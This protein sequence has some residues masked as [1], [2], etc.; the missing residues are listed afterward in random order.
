MLRTRFHLNKRFIAKFISAVDERIYC[1]LSQCSKCK[2]VINIDLL[3]IDFSSLLQDIMLNRFY[4]I[5]PPSV[6]DSL[7]D[8][9]DRNL[10]SGPSKC[11]RENTLIDTERKADMV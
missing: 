10:P 9:E 11:K 5:L 7:K 4:Y 6:L 8:L 1:W 3:L 2:I